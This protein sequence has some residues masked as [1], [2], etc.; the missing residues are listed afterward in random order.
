MTT[1]TIRSLGSGGGKLCYIAAQVVGEQGKVIGVDCNQEML[2]L[3]R[4]YQPEVA[5][6]IGYDNVSFRCGIIQNLALDL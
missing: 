3:A 2:S 1:I 4:R 6:K 5:E